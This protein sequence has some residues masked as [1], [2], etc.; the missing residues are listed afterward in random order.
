MEATARICGTR[1]IAAPVPQKHEIGGARALKQAPDAP[2]C[3]DE[4]GVDLLR[5]R[6]P[7]I[8]TTSSI[9]RTLPAAIRM[10]AVINGLRP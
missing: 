6:A 4:I 7:A 1:R 3:A 10:V 2:P 8:A 5:R 9:L